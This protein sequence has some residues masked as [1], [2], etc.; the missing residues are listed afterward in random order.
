M[1]VPEFG[2]INVYGTDVTAA[3]ERERLAR[4]NE[5]LLLN[6]LPEPIADRLR[7]GEPLIADRFDD[8]TLHVRRHRRLHQPV[9]EAVAASELVGVLNEV[10]SVFDGLVDATASRR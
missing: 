8:V 2:F 6:I 9:L 1:D 4:E 10:F 7:G 3:K 5:R